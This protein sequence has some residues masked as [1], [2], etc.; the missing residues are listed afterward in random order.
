[1]PLDQQVFRL[2]HR[3]EGHLAHLLSG[4][5]HVP[6][7]RQRRRQIDADQDP[8]R[9]PQARRGRAPARRRARDVRIAAQRPRPRHRHRLPGPGDGAVDEH[10]AKLLHGPRARD[11]PGAVPADQDGRSQRHRERGDAADRHRRPR[12]GPGGRDAV[13]RRAPVPGDLARGAF[14]RQ[15]A[16]PRRADLGARRP[17]GLDGV[18][19]RDAGEGTRPGRDLH[20][21]QRPPRLSGRR[22]VHH[23]QPRPQPRH[24]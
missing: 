7:R 2:R 14:R 24:L 23:A 5:G 20:Q 13:G 19:L 9:R 15:G 8:V 21:P 6:A 3:A 4:R 17:P 10:H 1:M 22:P 12:P 16:D 11:R 18:A